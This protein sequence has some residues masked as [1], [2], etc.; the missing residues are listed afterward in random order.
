LMPDGI[1]ASVI[2]AVKDDPSIY[3]LLESLA[4]QTVPL[5]S[6]EVIVV[7]NGSRHFQGIARADGPQVA[8]LNL[9]QP[10]MAAARNLGLRYA[11][12]RYLLLIDADCVAAPDWVEQMIAA[13]DKGY[14]GVGGKI[15]KLSANS[16][17][18]RYAIT[19]VDGQT[20]LNYLPALPLPY[21][22]G[23]KAGFVT[24]RVRDAGGFDKQFRSGN[25]VDLC[26]RLGLQG[27]RIGLAAE[28][29]V[30]HEDRRTLGAHYRRFRNYATY[31]VLLFAK[32]K[33]LSGKRFVVNRNPF[34]RSIQ[35]AASLPRA[36]ITLMGGDAGPL[37]SAWLQLVEAVAIWHGDIKGAIRYGQLYL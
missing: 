27:H 19:V 5:E 8:Y 21:V 9:V 30:S 3:R 15:K 25:D 1:L 4:V 23:A 31:Q 17:V 14:T 34:R 13:L 16:W 37:L 10:N 20:T 2:V 35:A 11:K 32:Y 6:Y 12:G 33:P 22:V 28:A 26:Y 7:E 36:L 29:I 24:Q 18:Q